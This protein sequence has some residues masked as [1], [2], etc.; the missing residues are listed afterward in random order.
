MKLTDDSN[1][2]ENWKSATPGDGTQIRPFLIHFSWCSGQ[3]FVQNPEY[4]EPNDLGNNSRC[5]CETL[6]NKV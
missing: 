1:H 4:N 6:D 2:G 5:H 3:E